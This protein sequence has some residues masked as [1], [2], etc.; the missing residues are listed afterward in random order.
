MQ[1]H[2]GFL[3]YDTMQSGKQVSTLQ[4]IILPSHFYIADGG[5]K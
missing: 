5:R 4:S 3:D 2:F 1:P